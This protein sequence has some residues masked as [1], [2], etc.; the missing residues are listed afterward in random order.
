MRGA[1][2]SRRK[3]LQC[4]GLGL[5]PWNKPDYI[6]ACGANAKIIQF[7]QYI[8]PQMTVADNNRNRTVF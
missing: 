2:A 3:S 5:F 8:P 1:G 4:K 6:P 7:P